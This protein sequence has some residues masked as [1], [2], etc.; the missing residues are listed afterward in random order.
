MTT[1][2]KFQAP[3]A[4]RSEPASSAEIIQVDTALES[5]RDSGFDL[6]AAA[7]EPIDNSIEA[8]ASLIRVIT[9][10]GDKQ[11]SIDEIAFADNGCG[12]DP[13]IVAH[14][15]SMGYSTRYGQRGKLGRFGVGLKL[16]AL[17]IGR[18]IDIYTK[19]P[20][21]V[22]IWHSYIDLDEIRDKVQR[23]I[24]AERIM[25]WPPAYKVAMRDT[26]G[27]PFT[28]GTLV[29]FGKI[30]KLKAGGH[31]ATSLPERISELRMYIARTYRKFLDK[32]LTVELN[33]TSI[34]LHDP[35]FLM[36]NPRIIQRYKPED[37]RG[38]VIDQGDFTI[39]KDGADY[40]VH[41]LVS[42]APW[43]FRH[44]EG[45]G[46]QRDHL[47]RN[48]N[49]YRIP[50]N[51]HNIS[52]LRNSREINYDLV[53]GL[54]P[55]NKGRG[56]NKVDRYIGVEIDFPAEL[57]EFFQ[58]RN[59]K[60]GAVPVDKLREEL[61]K[62]LERPVITARHQIRDHWTEVK[63]EEA[64]KKE[65]AHQEAIQAASDAAKE[66]TFPEGRAG[67]TLSP[68]D[69]QRI[70]DEVLDDL[71]V[72]AGTDEAVGIQA[73][74]RE[75]EFTLIDAGWPGKEMFEIKHLNGKSII[76]LNHR[77]PFM[78]EVYDSL[79]QA[80][81]NADLK[82]LARE[83]KRGLDIL[84]LAYAKAENMHKDPTI[85]DNLRSYWGQF[86][87]DYLRKLPSEE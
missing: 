36:D 70:I 84:I 64:Q 74:I 6:T 75:D 81:E 11:R 30:D 31:Y 35:L 65:K 47:D 51:Y 41:V 77:H 40:K 37:V 83:V 72:D 85:Y 54:F 43:Q 32:G 82:D 42:L 57:D 55:N 8:G 46:G 50:G 58:V 48:I 14:V 87:Q 21:D 63:T 15:L 28:S 29:I 38:T 61:K 24:T 2:P 66:K 7:G 10:Y 73:D 19:R 76:R 44:K 27:E 71:G 3:S 80:E 20:S 59:V 5:M 56:D 22:S 53:A 79:V 62:W 34:T 25:S 17:S 60:R 9:T 39:T 1:E 68:E 69:E 12:I 16:A 45:G 52:M 49:E 4:T 86:T 33:G 18:R 13:S 78:R 67:R 23:R 26:D